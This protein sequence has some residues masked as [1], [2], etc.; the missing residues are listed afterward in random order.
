MLENTDMKLFFEEHVPFL[1]IDLILA[2][3]K[4]FGNFH[5]QIDSL[6]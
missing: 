5:L 1:K 6:K 2:N 3:L 4:Q